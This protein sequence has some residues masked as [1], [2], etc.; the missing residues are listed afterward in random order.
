MCYYMRYH[1]L[2]RARFYS[3]TGHGAHLRL[4][5]LLVH[6]LLGAEG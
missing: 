4:L 6:Q 3:S 1:M 2:L 5:T